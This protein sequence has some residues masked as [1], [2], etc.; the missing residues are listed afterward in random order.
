MENVVQKTVDKLS[1]LLSQCPVFTGVEEVDRETGKCTIVLAGEKLKD[2]IKSFISYLE[3][4]DGVTNIKHQG[5]TAKFRFPLNS[6]EGISLDIDAR[7]KSKDKAEEFKE[8]FSSLS[9]DM[10]NLVEALVS[11]ILCGE[12]SPEKTFENAGIKHIP[13][14]K[15]KQYY[16]FGISKESLYL[17]IVDEEGDREE[18]IVWETSDWTKVEKLLKDFDLDGEYRDLLK[19]VSTMEGKIKNKVLSQLTSALQDEKDED[20]AEKVSKV[21]DVLGEVEVSEETRR[22]VVFLGHFRPPH[23]LDFTLLQK[24]GKKND[25]SIVCIL[26]ED[27]PGCPVT[28]EQSEKMWKIYKRYLDFPIEIRIVDDVK[29]LLDSLI[30]NE[31]LSDVHFTLI[32]YEPLELEEKKNVKVKLVP[33]ANRKMVDKL[34]VDSLSKAIEIYR[35]GN[36]VPMDINRDDSLKIIQLLTQPVAKDMLNERVKGII[37]DTVSSAGVQEASSGTPIKPACNASS[38][39]KEKLRSLYQQLSQQ[40]GQDFDV[41]FYGTRI[42][43]AS[44]RTDGYMYDHGPLYE[45][46]EVTQEFNYV[47]FMS[48]YI[49]YLAEC[50][51]TVTPLPEIVLNK[52]EQ[53]GDVFTRKT[54]EYDPDSKKIVLYTHG[55]HPKDVARSF[56][57]EY[58]HHLQCLEGK[59]GTLDGKF[60]TITEDTKL[61]ELEAEAYRE[62][63]ISFRKWTEIN[64]KKNVG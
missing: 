31:E 42:V 45:S 47:P 48:S 13:E 20:M 49:K 27:R 53:S 5:E 10:R 4:I 17:T 56:C 8:K 57:H 35:K 2:S 50:G 34:T 7:F 41:N 19:K 3:K 36:Y 46:E 52:E 63:N 62:G 16:Q 26:R 15:E 51:R 54:G 39:E 23:I 21:Q 28:A 58:Q 6:F 44:R 38:E 60:D 59:L 14:L 29:E 64:K 43:V 33:S 22:I 55:R 24:I 11:A 1:D 40:V 37:N 61:E 30:N 9:T 25:R 32:S 18:Y 12:S